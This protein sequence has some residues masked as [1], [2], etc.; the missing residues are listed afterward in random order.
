MFSVTIL[1]FGFIVRF[2][3]GITDRLLSDY[4]NMYGDHSAGSGHNALTRDE[5][6]ARGFIERHQDKLLFGSD[7][8]DT[9]G[10]GP[11]CQGAQILAALRRLAPSKAVERKILYENAK[12]LLKI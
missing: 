7:C 9:I 6:H 2:I 5:D 1:I 10:Q 11:G 3:L 4:P 12:R 8:I